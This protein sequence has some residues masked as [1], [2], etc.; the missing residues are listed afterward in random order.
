MGIRVKWSA[1][2]ERGAGNE[3]FQVFDDV[4]PT[5]VCHNIT[6]QRLGKEKKEKKKEK[7]EQR[8]KK[9]KTKKNKKE[10]PKGY[11]RDGPKN[12]FLHKRLVWKS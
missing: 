8:K 10:D 2:S 6:K 11:P 5:H 12:D 7:M 1:W 4:P 3:K 9:K